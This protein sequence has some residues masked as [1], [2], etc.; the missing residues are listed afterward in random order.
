M[1]IISRN[2]FIIT[3]FFKTVK[4]LETALQSLVL[5][6]QRFIMAVYKQY[7]YMHK[8]H[9]ALRIRICSEVACGIYCP[10]AS[11]IDA[12]MPWEE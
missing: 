7:N 10:T 2:R 12:I 8:M 9:A 1:D 6:Q 3:I 4:V 11:R 5:R